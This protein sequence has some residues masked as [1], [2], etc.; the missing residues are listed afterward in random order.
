MSSG[1]NGNPPPY[2]RAVLG[3]G[4]FPA[5]L[6]EPVGKDAMHRVSTTQPPSSLRAGTSSLLPTID[7]PGEPQSSL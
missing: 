5:A 7:L 3:G 1:R 6:R 4:F 2:S